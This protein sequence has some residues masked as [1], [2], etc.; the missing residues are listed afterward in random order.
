MTALGQ[1]ALP[2]GAADD[3]AL[4]DDAATR[5][6]AAAH[7]PGARVRI[8]VWQVPVRITHWVTAACIVI[9]SLTG[10][11]IADPFLIPPG[12]NVMTIVRL[13]HMVTALTLVA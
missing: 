9:L 2:A 12:G 5:D 7:A 10:G 6:S 1:T 4:V 11:Y 8:Y 3:A 13:I